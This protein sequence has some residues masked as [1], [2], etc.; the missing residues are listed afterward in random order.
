MTKKSVSTKTEDSEKFSLWL[1]NSLLKRLRDYQ[2]D[3]GVPVAV[4]IRKAIEAYL[5]TLPKSKR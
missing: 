3:V 2:A 1:D 4:S 5:E